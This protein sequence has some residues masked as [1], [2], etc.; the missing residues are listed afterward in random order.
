MQLIKKF[1][2]FAVE[3]KN[4]LLKPSMTVVYLKGGPIYARFHPTIKI[5]LFADETEFTFR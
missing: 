2:K 4:C 3:F 1:N 5:K